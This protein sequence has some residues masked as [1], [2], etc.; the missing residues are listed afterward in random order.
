MSGP[1]SDRVLVLNCGS[2]SVKYR[3]FD[4]AR[5]VAKGLVAY[6]TAD[7]QRLVGRRTEEIEA[8]LG[9]RGRDEMI[10]RDDLVLL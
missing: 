6:D 7:A 4:G 5:T 10:H 8:V 1:A 9:W 3:L 2:S